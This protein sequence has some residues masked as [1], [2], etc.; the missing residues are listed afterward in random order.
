MAM[1]YKQSDNIVEW[2]NFYG[3]CYSFRDDLYKI[4]YM[5]MDLYFIVFGIAMRS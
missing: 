3:E 4:V 1:E 5:Q 2:Y